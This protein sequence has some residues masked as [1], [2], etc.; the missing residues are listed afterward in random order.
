M[1]SWSG[2]W[3][4]S[5]A[6]KWSVHPVNIRLAIHWSFSYYIGKSKH[7]RFWNNSNVEQQGIGPHRLDGCPKRYTYGRHN[8]YHVYNLLTYVTSSEFTLEIQ[9]LPRIAKEERESNCWST[10]CDDGPTVNQHWVNVS[11]FPR[12]PWS[13][14]TCSALQELNVITIQF[15]NYSAFALNNFQL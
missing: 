6:V 13:C 14:S 15:W 7:Y 8:I 1:S 4:L 12:S 11:R 10:V 9:L 5:P 2:T 3:H